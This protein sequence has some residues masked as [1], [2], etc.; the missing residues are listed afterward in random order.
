MAYIS[1]N[2]IWESDD[3]NIVFKKDKMQVINLNQLKLEVHDTYTKDEE[4]TTNSVHTDDLDDI[5]K[6]YLDEKLPKI[7]VHIS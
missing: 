2:K 6:T 3:D 4:I 5:N 1:Y 7:D